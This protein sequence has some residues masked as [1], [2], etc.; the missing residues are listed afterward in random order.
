MVS[1][2][3]LLAAVLH[4]RDAFLAVMEHIEQDDMSAHGSAIYNEI[5]EYYQRDDDAIRCDV[6]LVR[7][8]LHRRMPKH[9][10][11]FTDML[12]EM[13]PDLGSVNVVREVLELKRRRAGEDLQLALNQGLSPEEM[14]PV[15]AEYT[16]LND[17]TDLYD[18][19]GGIQ[20]LE[21]GLGDLMRQSQDKG[22]LIKIL[23]ARL[24]DS[25]R[26]GLLPG[27]CMVIIGR[28][29]VGK[30]A[31]AINNIAGF[32]R[33]GKSTLLIENEDL[34]DDVKRRIGLRLCGVSMDWAE[35]NP[36][37][38]EERADKRGMGLL[39]IPDP[40]PGTVNEIRR[41]C[42]VLKPQVLVV[43][44]LRHLAPDKAAQTDGVGAIDR[45]GQGLR[46][47]GKQ[48]RIL[49]VL[50]GAAKE[51]EVGRDGLALEKAVLEKSDSYGSRTGVPGIADAMVGIGD[52]QTLKDRGMVCLHLCKNKRGKAEPIMYQQ[53]NLENCVFTDA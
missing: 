8:R 23:P 47:L 18:A 52:N 25:M 33:Q 32:L 40:V 36:D 2:S 28:V 51:G 26:G 30:S 29:N 19:S 14:A 38:F 22:E 17:S 9:K 45:V 21:T 46:A 1:E 12:R 3:G 5:V 31:L 53:V 41:A 13:T 44:Q 16:H 27:H 48:N 42:E 37:E 6:A 4:D 35:A 10:D 11:T 39:M 50:V 20:L 34:A 15:L 24:N 7:D 49:T 43:N